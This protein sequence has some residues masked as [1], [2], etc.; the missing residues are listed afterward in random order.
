M[1]V[2]CINKD[3]RSAI[4]LEPPLGTQPLV[5]IYKGRLSI[6]KKFVSLSFCWSVLYWGFQ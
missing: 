4:S 1:Q 2:L 6:V 3:E 5:A